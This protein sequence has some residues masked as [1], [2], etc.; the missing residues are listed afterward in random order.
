MCSWWVSGPWGPGCWSW[1]SQPD[2]RLPWRTP[3]APRCSASDCCCRN[4]LRRYWFLSWRSLSETLL[5]LQSSVGPTSR[6][7][8]RHVALCCLSALARI[9]VIRLGCG[10]RAQAA[11]LG[12]PRHPRCCRWLAGAAARLAGG[13]HLSGVP[14]R[15]LEACICS[16]ATA[17]L[18]QGL[19]GC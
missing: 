6:A 19:E 5:Y 17:C 7:N 11:F 10:R 13:L 1:L 4:P 9:A 18:W 8:P 2:C 12:E 15:P 16:Y 3:Q 14:R